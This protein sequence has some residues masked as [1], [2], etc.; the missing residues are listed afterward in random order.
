MQPGNDLERFQIKENTPVG[1]A[2][3]TLKGVDP[4]GMCLFKIFIFRKRLINICLH[5]TGRQVFYTISGDNF[6]VDRVTGVIT[7]KTPLDRERKDL[8]GNF[9]LCLFRF[10]FSCLLTF[11]CLLFQMSE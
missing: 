9:F 7:L 3:Y 1:E 2:V 6:S 8:L 10:F 5:F 11:F 4:K